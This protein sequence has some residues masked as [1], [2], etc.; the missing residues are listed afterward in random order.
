MFMFVFSLLYTGIVCAGR[1][2]YTMLYRP[3][4]APC[5]KSRGLIYGDLS[6][7]VVYDLLRTSVE[8]MVLGGAEAEERRN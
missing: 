5:K 7:S 2:A 1:S 4:R 8:R 6:K 3:H